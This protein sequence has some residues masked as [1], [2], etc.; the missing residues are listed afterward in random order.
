VMVFAE[1]EA[2]LK[3]EALE[4]ELQ[5]AAAHKDDFVGTMSHELRTPLHAI[6]G[7]S[8]ILAKGAGGELTPLQ[9]RYVTEVGDAAQELLGLIDDILMLAKLESGTPRLTLSPV[10]LV[11]TVAGAVSRLDL[12]GRVSLPTSDGDDVAVL[13]DRS[14]VE[15]ALTKLLQTAAASAPEGE[16]IRVCV[17]HE[18]GRALV[19]VR[20]AGPALPAELSERLDVPLSRVEDLRGPLLGLV[21]AQRVAAV[22]GGELDYTRAHGSNTF[23]LRLPEA[24]DAP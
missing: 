23:T 20:D 22:H 24:V 21:L 17:A 11:P 1:R 7:F 9:L 4:E 6:I 13:I 16:P 5:R 14:L 15:R 2:R 10:S 19:E 18:P 8:D 12:K 3:A